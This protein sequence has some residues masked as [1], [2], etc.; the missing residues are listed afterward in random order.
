VARADASRYE[1]RTEID[2]HIEKWAEINAGTL[3]IRR[4]S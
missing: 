2:A 1:D 4:A 3:V